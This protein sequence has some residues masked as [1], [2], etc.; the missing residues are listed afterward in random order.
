MTK[1]YLTEGIALPCAQC[2]TP[3]HCLSIRSARVHTE[4]IHL[5]ANQ[6]K[7]MMTTFISKTKTKSNSL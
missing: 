6:H 4:Y 5:K 1:A 7:L 2:L 3:T